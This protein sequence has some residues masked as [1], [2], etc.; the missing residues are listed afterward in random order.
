MSS[1]LN[2]KHSLEKVIAEKH[3]FIF[4][5][6]FLNLC[7]SAD[8]PDDFYDLTP[9]DYYRIMGDRIGGNT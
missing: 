2:T 6:Q 5:R 1:K 4:W 9:E 7:F 8:E 3:S